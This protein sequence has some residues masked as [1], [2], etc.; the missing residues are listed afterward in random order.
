M[1]LVFGM[2]SLLVV[3][4]VVGMLAKKQLGAVA[5]LQ[6]DALASQD[7]AGPTGASGTKNPQQLQEQV[8]Q[9]LEAAMQRPRTVDSE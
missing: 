1:R 6:K 7:A 5:V 2:I 8:R 4:A 9:S 3:L